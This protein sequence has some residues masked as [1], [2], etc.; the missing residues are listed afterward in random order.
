MSQR[1]A[2]PVAVT[3]CPSSRILSGP[4][5][6]FR[7]FLRA[8]PFVVSVVFAAGANDLK[9]VDEALVL[10]VG[11]EIQP[12]GGDILDILDDV[13]T[14]DGIGQIPV[15]AFDG[16]TQSV[17]LFEDAYSDF[18]CLATWPAHF[19][20]DD[21]WY[22]PLLRW[23]RPDPSFFR[24]LESYRSERKSLHG[25]S[26]DFSTD[27]SEDLFLG[28]DDHRAMLSFLVSDTHAPDWKNIE[29]DLSEALSR[30]VPASDSSSAISALICP[31]ILQTRTPVRAV[32]RLR[33]HIEEMAD[34]IRRVAHSLPSLPGRGP[35]D[36]LEPVRGVPA[37][38]FRNGVHDFAFEK[39]PEYNVFDVYFDRVAPPQG[40]VHGSGGREIEPE[41]CLRRGNADWPASRN[42]ALR[43]DQ[44]LR[45]VW[46]QPAASTIDPVTADIRVR[47]RLNALAGRT[48]RP[49]LATVSGPH[50]DR[51][52]G[53][54]PAL[55]A[56]PTNRAPPP[57]R[58]RDTTPLDVAASDP[59]VP[60]RALSPAPDPVVNAPDAAGTDV[61]A[62]QPA[63]EPALELPPIRPTVGASRQSAPH[64]DRSIVETWTVIEAYEDL[65]RLWHTRAHQIESTAVAVSR[66]DAVRGLL[67]PNAKSTPTGFG[68]VSDFAAFSDSPTIVVDRDKIFFADKA[69]LK[70]ARGEDNRTAFLTTFDVPIVP[71]APVPNLERPEFK[72]K[73][74][75]VYTLA[76]L[77]ARQRGESCLSV[78][79]RNEMKELLHTYRSYFLGP[80]Y[81]P[82]SELIEH[83][84][85]VLLLCS[86]Y[87]PAGDLTSAKLGPILLRALHTH[88][89]SSFARDNPAIRATLLHQIGE[90]TAR[91]YY[92]F[93]HSI[94]THFQRG[95]TACTLQYGTKAGCDTK[96]GTLQSSPPDET[97]LCNLVP[98]L[99]VIEHAGKTKD[100]K[101]LCEVDP[102]GRFAVPH[103]VSVAEKLYHVV[104]P[105]TLKEQLKCAPVLASVDS[106]SQVTDPGLAMVEPLGTVAPP[107]TGCGDADVLP[108][109]YDVLTAL[110]GLSYVFRAALDVAYMFRPSR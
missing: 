4:R 15:H 82:F 51:G 32:V 13:I 31:R 95:T 2:V 33:P 109:P 1:R 61:A 35:L 83:K 105:T 79:R 8:L 28:S 45:F 55:G 92:L 19:A 18:S 104:L 25:C 106:A 68:R 58:M 71:P 86:G 48:F 12:D 36:L 102:D 17:V 90:V 49:R 24:S 10:Y 110:S 34:L 93:G 97:A 75:S 94:L 72:I 99:R 66:A 23:V 64:A 65:D 67:P 26:P 43:L 89:P 73:Q 103:N 11:S 41:D 77:R 54:V 5:I 69:W 50:G 59:T 84:Q 70:T 9:S 100:L 91:R 63:K 96:G 39:Q 53:V 62:P 47:L 40:R 80:A 44:S 7:A 30:V 88:D 60:G 22:D 101:D 81:K 14:R 107:R 78:A 21:S 3:L 16:D 56:V 6:V 108:D 46:P 74:G 52:A 37:V 57:G 76:H 29:L 42:L 87:G 27:L 38:A 20:P 98:G 85:A